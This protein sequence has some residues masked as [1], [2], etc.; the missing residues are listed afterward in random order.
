MTDDLG[1]VCILGKYEGEIFDG[2]DR[3]SMG[4]MADNVNVVAILS[5]ARFVICEGDRFTNSTFV[6]D[7]DPTVIRINGDGKVGRGLRGSEQTDRHIKAIGTRVANMHFDAEVNNSAECLALLSEVAAGK[8][9]IPR[10]DR[11]TQPS[12]QSMFG[13]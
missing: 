6:R 13:L 8:K 12:V 10:K 3:L 7:F 4:I 11:T 9:D 2:S 1:A 5:G